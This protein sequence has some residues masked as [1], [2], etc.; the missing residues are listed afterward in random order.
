MVTG[1][2]ATAPIRFVQLLADEQRWRLLQE[3]ARSDRKV[4]E[5]TELVGKPQNLVSY[6]L[7]SLRNAGVVSSRRSSADRRDTY[8]RMDM[9]RCVS[10]I[11]G[12]FFAHRVNRSTT[13]CV[14]GAAAS[15]CYVASVDY[16]RLGATTPAA[17]TAPAAIERGAAAPGGGGGR[18]IAGAGT[19]TGLAEAGGGGA[20]TGAVPGAGRTIV[21]GVAM[22]ADPTATGACERRPGEAAPT[23][24]PVRCAPPASAAVDGEGAAPGRAGAASAAGGVRPPGGGPAAEGVA[25]AGAPA[26]RA[27]AALEPGAAGDGIARTGEAGGEAVVGRRGGG[28][29]TG[30]AG[31]EDPFPGGTGVV[32]TGGVRA[33]G[34]T[35]GEVN[36]LSVPGEALR[37]GPAPGGGVTAGR[38][39]GVAGFPGRDTAAP[40]FAGAAA[41]CEGPVGRRVTAGVAGRG[42]AAEGPADAESEAG[43]GPSR[44]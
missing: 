39:G 6:H 24:L 1:E 22:A 10:P 44:G 15:E 29:P 30:R 14:N 19:T 32:R 5:L 35:D 34:R 13:T 11:C 26:A 27:A 42:G 37:P 16:S 9:R 2:A 33:A 36:G 41:G 43:F 23:P 21:A 4:S 7:A 25:R 3:L 20:S 28:V 12:G 38:A 18:A 8:Y 31:A 40:E 17:A